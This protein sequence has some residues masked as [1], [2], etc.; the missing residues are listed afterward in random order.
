MKKDANFV[1]PVSIREM[2]RLASKKE[3]LCVVLGAICALIGGALQPY[4]LIIGGLITDVYLRKNDSTDYHQFWN[5][6]MVYIKAFAIFFAGSLISSF[7]QTFLLQRG[8]IGLVSRLRKEYLAAVLRQDAEWCDRT[9][10]GEV[11]ARLNECIEL[12]SS[13][14]G[15]KLG[16]LARGFSMFISSIIYCLLVDWQLTFVSLSMGPISAMILALMSKVVAKYSQ[17]MFE[18]S[19]QIY[20]TIEESVMNVKTIAACNGQR[21]MIDKLRKIQDSGLENCR[22]YN[23]WAGFFDGMSIAAVYVI[24]GISLWCVEL[25]QSLTNQID[26]ILIVNTI[27]M[28]GY[29][30]GLLGPH[31]MALRKAREACAIIYTVIDREP[32]NLKNTKATISL[33]QPIGNIVF[34]NVHFTYPTRDKPVLQGY[35]TE[36]G[37]GGISLSGGQNQRIAIARAIAIDP[38]ILLLDEATSALDTTSER[39]VQAALN[40]AAKGRTTIVIAHR[41]STLK[42]VDRIYLIERGKVSEIGKLMTIDQFECV[43]S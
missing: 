19:G 13:G 42:D 34:K 28:T 20:S 36:L 15:D 17:R 12:I 33:K 1:E 26:V 32:A 43:N 23:F 24:T 16:L 7:L 22:R 35:D 41:L 27:C 40:R 14:L 5:D 11:T 4:V 25:H 39:I 37:P 31:M 6:V 30:L 21:H 3:L 29:L 2:F 10:S 8:C 18:T 38:K 9:S